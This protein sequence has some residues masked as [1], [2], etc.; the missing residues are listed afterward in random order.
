M[1]A[2]TVGANIRIED[3]PIVLTQVP[4]VVSIDAYRFSPDEVDIDILH[5][6]LSA[7]L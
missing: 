5:Q 6:L 7:I 2:L 4:S 1:S 3:A